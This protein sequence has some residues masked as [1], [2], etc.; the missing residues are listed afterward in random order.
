[1]N[2]ML[3]SSPNIS[4]SPFIVPLEIISMA[5]EYPNG[6][7]YFNIFGFVTYVGYYIHKVEYN[8]YSYIIPLDLPL[9]LVRFFVKIAFLCFDLD[10]V[11]YY[12]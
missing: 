8:T 12:L 11:V 9:D 10:I 1:M 6:V 4:M 7:I 3:Y 5:S 2:I